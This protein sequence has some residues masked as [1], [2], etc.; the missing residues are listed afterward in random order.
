VHLYIGK[1]DHL[2]R[3]VVSEVDPIISTNSPTRIGD[4]LDDM[5]DDAAATINKALPKDGDDS[6]LNKRQGPVRTRTVYDNVI[7]PLTRS[8]PELFAFKPPPGSSLFTP[9]GAPQLMDPRSRTLAEL[10]RKSRRTRL[11]PVHETSSPREISP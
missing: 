4:A 7:S 9:A 6:D 11:K 8:E 5:E 10:I 1:E 2:L 3:R